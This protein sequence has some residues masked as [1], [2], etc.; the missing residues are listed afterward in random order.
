MT[1]SK[2]IK[3]S[4]LVR[5][6]VLQVVSAIFLVYETV[7]ATLAG[8][9]LAPAGSLDCALR[10]QWLALYRSKDA[11][12]IRAVQDRYNCCG[13]ASMRDMAWPFPSASGHE[14]VDSC[15]ER[16]QRDT[17]CL[18]LWRDAERRVAGILLAVALA[19]FVW[20]VW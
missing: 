6:Y 2:R 18:E 20:Q 7:L 12:S 5:P 13:L 3:P 19:V 16:Y 17:P 1:T 8:T 15:L 10:E 9:H 11:A 4:A 14:T